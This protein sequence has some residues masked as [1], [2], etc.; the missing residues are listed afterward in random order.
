MRGRMR[1]II[2]TEVALQGTPTPLFAERLVADVLF[3]NQHSTNSVYFS[4]DGGVTKATMV[5]R[6]TWT[7]R[8]VDLSRLSVWSNAGGGV[9]VLSVFGNTTD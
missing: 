9:T 6:A 1:N 7:L 4:T 2:A 8:G 5:G 3:Y